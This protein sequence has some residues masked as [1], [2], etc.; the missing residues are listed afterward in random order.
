MRTLMTVAGCLALGLALPAYAQEEPA[1]EVVPVDESSAEAAPAETEAPAVEDTAAEA[2]A[3]EAAAAEAP[4][5][6]A[7]AE[8]AA[9]EPAEPLALYVGV[10]WVTSTLSLSG[11]PG[12]ASTSELDSG[13][14]RARVGMRALEAIGLELQLGIDNSDSD[15]GSVETESYYG[16]FLVP[17]ATVFEV[18]ELA[19]PVGY[20][21]SSFAKGSASEDYAS[22]AYG[23]DAEL[24]IRTFGE[25]LP[26]LRF[27]LGWMVYYQKSDARAYGANAGVRYDFQTSGFHVG[28]PFS[29]LAK[30]WPFGGDDAAEA[31]AE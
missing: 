13:M 14:Y 18:V 20:A 8:E 2:P 1:A 29:G 24:P 6:E 30:L 25:G 19:F 21:Q 5:E 11:S 27:T 3:E 26:D 22:I 15:V 31:P 16:V 12:A 7:P 28:N 17:T 10:D 9:A 4:A 23:V